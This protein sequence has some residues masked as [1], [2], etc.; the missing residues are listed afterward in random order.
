MENELFNISYDVSPEETEKAFKLFQHKFQLKRCIL[1]T[2]AY[3][4]A[5]ALGANLIWTDQS[6]IFGYVLVALATGMIASIWIKPR[7]ARKRMIYTISQ[8]NR[9][10][11][12]S[13]FYDDKIIVSTRIIYD[14][15]D[16]T[17]TIALTGSQI[18]KIESDD[19]SDAQESDSRTKTDNDDARTEKAEAQTDN[20]EENDVPEKEEQPEPTVIS[21]TDDMYEVTEDNEMFITFLNRMLIYIYP[22][23]CLDDEQINKLR[24]YFTDKNLYI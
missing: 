13:S 24:E 4:I 1:F 3:A 19:D 12:V 15:E 21:L 14:E 23:R 17:E 11:Y 10:T 18:V 2:L 20:S 7:I 8:L 22:K 9:E 6:S 16:K 5:L